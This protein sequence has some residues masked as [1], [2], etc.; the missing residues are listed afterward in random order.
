MLE[1]LLWHSGLRSRLQR[2]GLCGGTGLIPNWVQGIKDQA[3][4]QPWL[5]FHPGNSREPRV[6]PL[7][8]N[9]SL[10]GSVVTNPA[11]IHEDMGLIPGLVQDL[12][13]P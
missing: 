12:V 6:Q 7:K 9:S 4:L 13:L 10:C 5:R 8:I 1:F 2:L 11:G 3:L